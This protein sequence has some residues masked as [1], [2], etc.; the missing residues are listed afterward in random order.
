MSGESITFFK[1]KGLAI[2]LI[3]LFLMKMS[4]KE[5][6]VE[7]EG[8]VVLKIH[9]I[10][11]I[12]SNILLIAIATIPLIG[13]Y[14]Q[15]E[16]ILILS[17]VGFFLFGSLAF[18]FLLFCKNYKVKFNDDK[19]IVHNWLNKTKEISWEEITQ[20]KSKVVAGYIEINGNNKILKIQHYLVGLKSFTQKMEEKTK[21]TARDLKLPF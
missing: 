18:A 19:I 3:L 9:K 12:I 7:T 11:Q 2:S 1:I 8:F 14:R 17:V 20:I 5:V 16:E 13:I 21:W 10:V 15:D 6:E 4:S